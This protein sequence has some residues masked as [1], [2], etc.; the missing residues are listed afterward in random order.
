[1]SDQA[2]EQSLEDRLVGVLDQEE[3]IPPQDEEE[4]PQA[5]AQTE[6]SDSEEDQPD[7]P[8]KVT[9]K[10]GDEEVEVDLEEAKNLAQMGYDYTKKTQEVAE[11]RKQVEMY[12]QAVKAQEQTLV[13]QAQMQQAFIKDLAKV[14]SLSDQ[15]S[16]YENL[17]WNALSDSDPV[18]AQKLYFN[19]QNLQNQR[20]QAQQEIQNKF[21]QMQ[22]HKAQQDSIRLAQAQAELVKMIPDWNAEKAQEIRQA[23]KEYG[24]TEQEL[25]SITDPKMVRV[26]ADANAYRKLQSEKANITKKVSDKPPVVKPGAKDTKRAAQ[27]DYAK[28]RQALKRSGNGDIAAKLIERML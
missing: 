18:Q 1:M 17:N 9:L 27:A 5:E 8:V 12:A 3:G 10:R 23:G 20:T 4:S 13:Q 2:Q 14:E 24:F 6:D 26:L 11:Q 19:Y 28:E 22:S 21:N 16:Q 15:I 7:E 25:S